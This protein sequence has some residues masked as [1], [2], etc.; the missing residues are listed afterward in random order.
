MKILQ[1]KPFY[2]WKRYWSI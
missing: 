2:N 1:T